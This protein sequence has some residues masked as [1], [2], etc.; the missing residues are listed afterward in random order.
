MNHVVCI[1]TIRLCVCVCV[2]EMR[3]FQFI[4]IIK[5]YDSN[6]LVARQQMGSLRS[7]KDIYTRCRAYRHYHHFYRHKTQVFVALHMNL[8]QNGRCY[9]LHPTTHTH[10][11][12]T[13]MKTTITIFNF[14]GEEKKLAHCSVVLQMAITIEAAEM[15]MDNDFIDGMF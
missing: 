12:H 10:T 1:K 8:M 2:H 13:N 4:G 3:I 15:E 5:V 6:F 7:N 9:R 14:C 11:T